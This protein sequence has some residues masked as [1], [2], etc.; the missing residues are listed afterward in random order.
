[1]SRRAHPWGLLAALAVGLLC[2]G[3]LVP[4]L[5]RAGTP[6]LGAADWAALRFTLGQAALSA[7]LSGLLAVPV[8]RALARRSFPGRGA[9]VTLMG[10]P[11]IL[12]TVVAILGILAVF[13]RGGW[14]NDA[15][16]T[17]GLPRVSIYGAGGVVL[18]HV[19]LNLPLA[20]RL[21][22]AGWLAIPAERFRLAASLHAPVGALL[23]RPMLRQVLPGTL[24]AIFALCL[25]SFSVAL[26]LG[27]GP[28]AT[29]VELGIY[30]KLRFEADFAG[31]ATLALLQYAISGAAALLAARLALGPVLGG[32]LGGRV[33]RWDSQGAV[34]RTLDA[35]AIGGAAL[36]LLL[37]LLAVALRG[38]PGL[39]EL[40]TE[41][42]G[43]ALRSLVVAL[44]AAALAL[45][46]ALP[47]ALRGGPLAQAM[48]SLPLAASP[49]VLG[50][51]LLLVLRP[52]VPL[53]AAALPVTALVDALLALPFALRA[54]LPAVAETQ[55]RTG[56]LA[57]ALGL[58]GW[59]WLRIAVLPAIRPALG[60]GAGLAAALSAGSLGAVALF[61]GDGGGTLPL[62]MA[63]LMGAYRME[64]AAGVGLLALAL[65]LG[66][67]QTFDRL[68]GRPARA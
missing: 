21:L 44:T 65:A 62:L 28:A 18:A 16:A 9:L 55:A 45:L 46:M 42:A 22:L 15:L 47:L 31:A 26:I 52:L 29:T 50:A 27:G 61:A 38:L 13:G 34:P 7:A 39:A 63:R 54:L 25:T 10:A 59:A 57:E 11:F 6:S 12:P 17:L 36:L 66:L 41:A 33:E 53:G 14:I 20:T 56:R 19:V 60:L 30:Q 35:L 67:F 24:A 58:R 51:G 37:P 3:P 48:G 4:L 49:L 8:A 68:G 2:L 40:P 23:E 5:L 43:A 64:A 32:G 1:M